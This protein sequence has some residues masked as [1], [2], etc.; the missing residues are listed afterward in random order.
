M[1]IE[2]PY[3]D[4]GNT[5]VHGVVREDNVQLAKFLMKLAKDDPNIFFDKNFYGSCPLHDAAKN[6]RVELV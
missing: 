6:G 3:A 4:C 2:H 1:K 5:P